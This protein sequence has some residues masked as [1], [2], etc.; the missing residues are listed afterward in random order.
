MKT[1][2]CSAA[3][4]DWLVD[5]LR[6]HDWHTLLAGRRQEWQSARSM[7]FGHLLMEKL[8]E[9]AQWQSSASASVTEQL[10]DAG[11]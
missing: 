2:S 3:L 1:P 4:P 9:A 5:A 7:I 10:T 11:L 6:R 8:M